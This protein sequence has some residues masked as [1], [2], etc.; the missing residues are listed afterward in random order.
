MSLK[1]PLD[2]TISTFVILSEAKN[3]IIYQV[4]TRSFRRCCINHFLHKN[5]HCEAVTMAEAIQKIG[6]SIKL[7]VFLDRHARFASSR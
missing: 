5:R 2:I 7:A 1:A 3:L 6:V 4:Q